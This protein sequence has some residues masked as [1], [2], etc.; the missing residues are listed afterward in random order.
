[1]EKARTENHAAEEAAA[2]EVGAAVAAVEEVRAARLPEELAAEEKLAALGA[3]LGRAG[4]PPDKPNTAEQARM[5]QGQDE[6]A[7]LMEPGN[8]LAKRP[9]LS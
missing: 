9:R 4:W 7:E 6:Q 5:M 8:S 3:G 2:Q 1:M